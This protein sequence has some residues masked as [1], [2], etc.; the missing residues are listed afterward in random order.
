MTELS[1]IRW[2]ILGTGKIARKFAHDVKVAAPGAELKAVGSRSRENAEAFGD[3][4]G[5]P[6]RHGSYEQ[7]TA[8]PEIDVVYIATPH[9]W[10]KEMT[11]LCLNADKA[12]LCEK[13]FAMNAQQAREMVGLARE[14]NL[15]LME[16]MWTRF[17][18]AMVKLRELV[19]NDAIGEIQFLTASVGWPGG[20]HYETRSYAK[21]L[22]GGIMLDG[23]VY[24]ISFAFD[25]LGTPSKIASIGV[26]GETEVDEQETI[27]FGYPSGAQA[28]IF[29]SLR[30]AL[31]G[32]AIVAGTK[33]RIE[34]SHQWWEPHQ[35]TLFADGG[36]PEVFDFPENNTLGYQYEAIAVDEALRAGKTESEIMPLDETITIME[37]MDTLRAQ[38]GLT[39]P[40]DNKK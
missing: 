34:V 7:L 17:R 39:Y 24:P 29:G 6:N 1:T 31:R 21:H 22:G 15:F 32:P 5:I 12:V 30:T 2:G 40:A 28:M 4:F 10:H 19:A 18:P 16:A 35:I 38:W 9:P 37:T 20:N 11:M 3:E 13:A 33:G 23:T 8:D 25:L 27:A 36:E 26:L 14:K